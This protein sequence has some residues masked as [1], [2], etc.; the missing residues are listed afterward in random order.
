MRLL[1][2]IANPLKIRGQIQVVHPFGVANPELNE[3][4]EEEWGD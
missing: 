2:I 3:E 1:Q 4:M